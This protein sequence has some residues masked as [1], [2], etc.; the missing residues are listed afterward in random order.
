MKFTEK[1]PPSEH[2]YELFLTTGWNEKYELS[3]KELY[4]ALQNSWYCISVFDDEQLIGFGRIICD[5]VVH[6][7]ILDVIIHPD[8]Q[9]KGIGK[10]VMIKLITKCKEHKI[11]DIQLFSAKNKCGF[12]KKLGFK[13]RV[14]NSPGMKM[15]K[16]W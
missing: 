1:L 13:N 4:L 6:A 7:L 9:G 14:E 10:E 11:R 15:E 2:F 5:G 8:N 16:Y 12:Y 3:K